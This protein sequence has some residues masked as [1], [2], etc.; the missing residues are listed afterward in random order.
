MKE[1]YAAC[2]TATGNK[3]CLLPSEG[4]TDFHDIMIWLAPLEFF[5]LI[6]RSLLS[7]VIYTS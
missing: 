1:R 5:G 2:D 6:M 3:I 7:S 4:G